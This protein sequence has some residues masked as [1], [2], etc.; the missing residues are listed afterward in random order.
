MARPSCSL[1]AWAAM[2]EHDRPRLAG[3]RP[4]LAVSTE[5]QRAP[6][7]AGP[8]FVPSIYFQRALPTQQ[9]EMLPLKSLKP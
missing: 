8:C 7:L 3:Y 9:R 1:A 5:I 6:I 2:R 4:L